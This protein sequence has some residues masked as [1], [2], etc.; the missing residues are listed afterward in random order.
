MLPLLLITLVT[1]QSAPSPGLTFNATL[2]AVRIAA[3]P[4]DVHTRQFQLSTDPNQPRAQ[5]RAHFE[6][7]WRSEDGSQSFYSAPGAIDQSCARW[8]SANPVEAALEPGGTLTIRYTIAV[9]AEIRAGGYWCALTV[10]QVPDPLVQRQGVGVQFLASVST[11]IFID[12]GPVTRAAD[13]TAVDVDQDR[14][15]VTMHN[16]G[17]TPLAV[18]GRLEFRERGDA[19]PRAVLTVPRGT[20]LPE[21]VTTGRFGAPLPGTDVLPSGRYLVRAIMDIGVEH[22]LGAEREIHVMRGTSHEADR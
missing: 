11:G 18:E 14:A 9:P 7:W 19:E 2:G 3:R 21:R 13:I 1:A 5:F 12:V 4:G 17:N 22:Y 16:V 8:A 20:L 10:D 15:I 6:D